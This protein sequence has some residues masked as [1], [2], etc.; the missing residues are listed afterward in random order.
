MYILSRPLFRLLIVGFAG[1]SLN[2]CTPVRES[3]DGIATGFG[4]FGRDVAGLFE[5]TS[6][7][8]QAEVIN[9]H[10]GRYYDSDYDQV[11]TEMSD[12]QIQLYGLAGDMPQPLMAGNPKPPLQKSYRGQGVPA[13]DTS[14]TV[15][16]LDE[17]YE[18]APQNYMPQRLFPATATN[19]KRIAVPAP[20]MSNMTA[21]Q[22]PTLQPVQQGDGIVPSRI[23][24]AHD[25]KN[26]TESGRNVVEHVAQ[27]YNGQS[28]AVEGHASS[29]SEQ[30]TTVERKIMNLRVSM[31]RALTVS[32]ALMQDG[33]PAEAIE[34]K[35]FGDTKPPLV[36][37]GMD[38]E[39][40]ARRVEVFS[41]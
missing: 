37:V 29:R 11:A 12:S 34:T 13:A 35:A 2:A 6:A 15:Y 9:Y 14:V 36:S 33:V 4:N 16:P 27:S 10:D 30:K 18:T 39:A 20:V 21:Q 3:A 8:D 25:S 41:R 26:L 5:G 7:E 23:Y 40:A 31:D 24:F 38:P 17:S 19:E 1:M 22:R 28:I 32:R